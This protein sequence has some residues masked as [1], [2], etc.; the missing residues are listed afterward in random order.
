MSEKILSPDGKQEWNGTEWVP[1]SGHS[2]TPGTES[3]VNYAELCVDAL[4][5]GD[6]ITAKSS[7][8]KAKE[9]DFKTATR[10]FESDYALDIGT[11]YANIVE[12]KL[13]E[14]INTE[15]S[16][17]MQNF[18]M[19]VV[20]WDIEGDFQMDS[21]LQTL[22]IAFDNA[23]KFLG[24]P[25]KMISGGIDAFL[26]VFLKNF[27]EDGD[28][29]PDYL[30]KQVTFS[31]YQR[32]END[33]ELVKKVVEELDITELP[34]AR[35]IKQQYRIGWCLQCAGVVILG[36]LSPVSW[37]VSRTE[38]HSVTCKYLDQKTARAARCAD[39][40]N[41]FASSASLLAISAGL[42]VHRWKEEDFNLIQE[43][44][45]T[46]EQVW[47]NHRDEVNNHNSARITA[48]N[49][50]SNSD[51]FIATAAYG[52][53]YD[54]KID[55]LRNWRDD[56]LREFAI[57]RTFIKIYYFLSPPIAKIVSKSKI[58]RAIVRIILS[59]IIHV[60]APKFKRPRVN[61]F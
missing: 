29:I 1:L 38:R 43:V 16:A 20:N 35:A 32:M 56:S 5:R 23:A 6:M 60:L 39:K 12:S 59:P 26:E 61:Q 10:I 27:D 15:F 41:W 14:I 19:G 18:G 9:L 51:C 4:N 45:S 47:N 11:G 7:Y 17:N 49:T 50:A 3:I 55:V 42:P 58:L 34:D 24:N 33:L 46:F 54:S 40:A 13:V 21:S 37:K 53:P 57:G 44:S 25:E 22:E 28:G 36:R 48:S 30:Q 31:D 52:T 8:D 2:T